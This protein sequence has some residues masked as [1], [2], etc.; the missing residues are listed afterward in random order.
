MPNMFSIKNTRLY[1]ELKSHPY[2]FTCA[3]AL[4]AF[5]IASG[6]STS[7][8][9]ANAGLIADAL[10]KGGGGQLSILSGLLRSALFNLLIY[11]LM[12]SAVFLKPLIPLSA[13][14]IALKGFVIGFTANQF[15]IEFG[16]FG[17]VYSMLLVVLPSLYVVCG[18]VLFFA[19][20]G[21]NI[22]AAGLSAE[23]LG[24]FRFKSRYAEI[25][26]IKPFLRESVPLLM[27]IVTEGV[28]SQLVMLLL[29]GWTLRG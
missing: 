10:T 29:C 24:R 3:I 4:L 2:A 19:R 26:D 17:A 9:A 27:G 23:T 11:S 13:F 15:N 18:M 16:W 22:F 12:A 7:A 21:N 5:G 25:T 14:A 1:A 20:A 6:I 8:M 28:L